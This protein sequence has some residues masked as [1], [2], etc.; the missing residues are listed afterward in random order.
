[1]EDR[2]KNSFIEGLNFIELGRWTD[3]VASFDMAIA[4]NPD[5]Y[6]AWLNRGR[7]LEFLKRY[8]EALDSCDK[9][10]A[11]NPNEADAWSF[12]AWVLSNLGKHEEAIS[13][14]DRAVAINPDYEIVLDNPLVERYNLARYS[15]AVDSWDKAIANNP[16]DATLWS[17]RGDALRSLG[18]HEEAIASY[19]K[20]IA[21]NPNDE[22]TWNCRGSVQYYLGLYEDAIKS[23]DKAIAINP[24]EATLWSDR[25]DALSKLGQ[26]EEAIS[27]YDRAI[28]IN[29]NNAITWFNRG[30]AQYNLA[31]YAEAVNSYDKA[32][33]INPNDFD[34][35]KNREIA[36]QQQQE[37]NLWLSRLNRT[38]ESADAEPEP[39]SHFAQIS[40]IPW[41]IGYKIQNRYEI[42]DIK[43]GGMGIV[44]LT[45]DH[46]SNKIFAIKTF[47]EKYLWD[48]D[49]IQRFM[50]EAET[51]TKLEKHT[52]IVYANWVQIID[53]KP[54]LFLEYID[55]GNL[56]QFIGT[57]T[58]EE[59]LDFAIQ[60]CTGMEYAYQKLG[61]I[62]NDIKP[63]N[64]MV[65][66]DP[67]FKFGKAY[68]VTDFGLVR[69]L[70]DKFWDEF[71][72][73]SNGIGTLP[74]MPPEQFPEQIQ[75]K[76]SINRQVTTRSDIYS[77]G[78]TLYLLLTGKIPFNDVNEIFTNSPVRPKDLNPKVPEHLDKLIFKCLEKNSNNRYNDFT[79]L[80][81]NLIEI[82]HNL[83]GDRYAIVGKKVPLTKSNW[84]NK[85]LAL[86]ELGKHQE[87]IE[88]YDNSLEIN[89]RDISAWNNKGIALKHL[90]KHQEAMGCF[91]KAL[92]INPRDDAASVNKGI[93]LNKLGKYD[94]AIGCF[95]KVLEIN[96]RNAEAWNNKGQSLY[97]LGKPLEAI[98]C[99]DKSLEVNPRNDHAL[100][101]KGQ[102]LYELGKHQEAIGCFEKS[103]EINPR[104]AAAWYNKGDALKEFGKHQ[105]AIGCYEKF[106]EFA[107]PECASDVEKI[108]QIINQ[109]RQ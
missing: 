49:I 50:A 32:L 67:R 3:A 51:W 47:Q 91:D 102:S 97:E 16:K 93:A 62:H 39:E 80:K 48:E 12:R 95:D 53:G 20:A 42:L 7:S 71:D 24:K 23:W 54:L 6:E 21:I 105:E 26:H 68:K 75:K 103:L 43:K 83:T 61:I 101:N 19:D 14:Y 74:F 108:K 40:P 81:F 52:N 10:I 77:F 70:S 27:S 86:S 76:F 34:A 94:D 22:I 107:S 11:I 88:C 66:K 92:E 85:G 33:A 44:Y 82:Y 25:G 1:M 60:F 79:E 104:N 8:A 31:W 9:A 41:D 59:S 98:R 4:I 46:E 72:K 64:V 15:E 89:P 96:P 84:N 57:L 45:H 109:L 69:V 18:K 38:R 36:L 28:A 35:Q 29:P 99:Y 100:T 58:V 37:K 87:A 55:S 17:N 56:E 78:V 5:Y 106:I 63:G 90:G 65:Q 2:A 30:M 13:S 73:I